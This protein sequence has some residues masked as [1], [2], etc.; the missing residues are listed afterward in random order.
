V[1]SSAATPSAA[2]VASAASSRARAHAWTFFRTGGIDQVA[3]NSGED[4]QHLGELDQKLWVALSCPVKGLEID[5]QT[6][7]LI[8]AAEDDRLLGLD[9]SA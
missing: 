5:E 8:D 1:Y 2:A 6:L 4:L 9:E 3:L 7:A